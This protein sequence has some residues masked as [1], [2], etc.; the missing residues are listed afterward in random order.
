MAETLPPS[1]GIAAL[2][3]IP[4]AVHVLPAG[5]EL[6][7]VWFEASPH[8]SGFGQFRYFGPVS[9]RFDHHLPGPGDVPKVGDRGI[10]YAVEAHADALITALGEVFQE[11]RIID[12]RHEKPVASIFRIERDLALLDLTAHWATRAGASAAISSGPRAIARSWSRDFYAAY[13]A[14]DG[15]RYRASMSGG[16]DIALALYERCKNAMPDRTITT[17]RLDHPEIFDNVAEAA[18]RLGYDIRL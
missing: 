12:L 6:L 8:P 18:R 1:P 13:P 14:I 17:K 3:T 10:L 2:S 16:S 15:L 11:R 5:T 7:R 4:P 9:S